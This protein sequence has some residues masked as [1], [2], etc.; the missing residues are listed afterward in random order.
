MKKRLK[1]L[2]KQAFETPAPEN[3]DEF[4][5]LLSERNKNTGNACRTV[6]EPK[7][8]NIE[9]KGKGYHGKT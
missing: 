2:I 4:I 8:N 3:R 5:S 7:E 1:N 9:I 6:S